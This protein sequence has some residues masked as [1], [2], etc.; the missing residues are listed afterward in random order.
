MQPRRGVDASLKLVGSDPALLEIREIA[1]NDQN[2]RRLEAE[3][4]EIAAAQKR[5]GANEP[6]G[7]RKRRLMDIDLRPRTRQVAKRVIIG[8]A[9]VV[10]ADRYLARHP[11]APQRA[12]L[13]AE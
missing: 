10:V 6:S 5:T 1:S 4:L 13:R 3:R 8:A 11:V 12:E 7:R 9:L 2:G